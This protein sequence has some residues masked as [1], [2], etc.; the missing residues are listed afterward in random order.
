MNSTADSDNF[1]GLIDRVRANDGE[2]IE[3][4][5]RQFE[6][7]VRREIRVGLARTACRNNVDADDVSQS[8]WLSFF[9]RTVAGQYQLESPA[10]LGGLLKSMARNKLASQ[11]RRLGRGKRDFARTRLFNEIDDVADR[12]DDPRQRAQLTELIATVSSGLSPEVQQIVELR[13][14]GLSWAEVAEQMGGTAQ[15]RRMQLGRAIEK[16]LIKADPPS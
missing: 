1:T 8:V 3:E 16:A 5:F 4:I 14:K 10:R 15:G 11:V 7:L 12:D 6:P 13:R 2:A 9:S